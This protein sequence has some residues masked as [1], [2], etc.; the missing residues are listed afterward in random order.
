[1]TWQ[2]IA[3]APEGEVI[4]GFWPGGHQ[5]TGYVVKGQW[6]DALRERRDGDRWSM[7]VHWMELP[8]PPASDVPPG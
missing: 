8:A 5:H 4:L 7:P 3:T 2:P 6:Y 1:M